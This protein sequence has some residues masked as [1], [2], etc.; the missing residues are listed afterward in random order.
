[1]RRTTTLTVATLLGLTL[2]APTTSASAAGETCRGEAAT[3]VGNG[4]TVT[5]TEGRDVIVS[6]SAGVI[7]ALGGDDLI[8]VAVTRTN[9]NVLSVDAGAGND[10][11]DTTAMTDDG[12]Y[13]TTTLGAGADTFAGGRANDTV[14]G[15][16]RDEPRADTERDVVDTAEG[17][18][19]VITGSVGAA[20]R[21]SVTLGAGRDFLYLGSP[22]VASDAVLDG[23]VGEDSMRLEAGSGDLALDMVQGTFTTAHGAARFTAFEFTTLDVGTGTVTYRGTEGPDIVTVRPIAGV[24]TLDVVTGGGDDDV[25]LE[26]AALAPGSRIDTGAGGDTL[27]TATDTGRLALDLPARRLTV[28]AVDA[29]AVGIED[30][31]LMAPEVVMVGDDGDNQ[32]SWTGCDANL[33]GGLGDD[34]LAQRYDY[35]FETYEFRCLGEVSLNGGE[36][37]DSLRGSIGEDLLIGDRGHD[38]IEGRGS[39]DRIRGSRGNDKADGGEGRDQVSGGAGDDVVNG[40]AG[41]DVLLGGPGRD[42]VDGSN[43]RDRCLAEHK[44]RCER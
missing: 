14:H 2:L 21:D 15:G 39:A 35:L 3:I 6:A 34:A 13:I 32:L 17:N 22:A 5:G 1:M 36:G 44:Q 26:P 25:T 41:D 42:R 37:R 38:T 31:F 27:V 7:A 28:G 33:R 16:E 4:P 43:G 19:A 24:P 23:G 30:A 11:V 18:D 29:V 8:C 9:S 12:Y 20:N 40:R 10:T